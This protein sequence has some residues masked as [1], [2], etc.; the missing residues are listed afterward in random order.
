MPTVEQIQK[1]IA[2]LQKQAAELRK[3]LATAQRDEAKETAAARGKRERAGR[4]SSASTVR[5]YLRAAEQH[6][7]KA[8]GSSTS[9][10]DLTKKLAENSNKQA[11]KGRALE[12][13]VK[14]AT[15]KRDQEDERR[16]QRE[17]QHARELSRLQ[18]PRIIYE[19]RLI[20]TPQPE[21]LRVLYLAANP[22]LDLRVDAEVR[23]VRE[24][25]R[26]ALLRD[27][28][29]LDHWPAATPE[30]LLDGLSQRRPH[31][32]HFSGHGSESILLFD[33]AQI[34]RETDE[35]EPSPGRV[36]PFALLA[37][38]LAATDQPP[39]LLVLNACESLGGAENLL[40]AVPVVIGMADS[41]SDLAA[42]AFSTR[43]YAAIADGQSVGAA[44]RQ[45]A[46][47]VD[48]LQ[49]SEGWKPDVVARQD[50]DLDQLVLVT[51]PDTASPIA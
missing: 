51:P 28:V 36:V 4:S 23:S 29:D 14:A 44:L 41:I 45:A 7:K 25:I 9:I 49:L 38:A 15:R 47:A 43:F 33:D 17:K 2:S 50:V 13:A 19:T 40:P 27:L 31:V 18:S 22:D 10:A 21:K 34:R 6:E 12:A 1:E 26:K 20:P 35:D 11:D 37:R 42:N 48:M 32:V 5:M 8:A 46:V 39:R 3:R 24:A 16:R 30:D